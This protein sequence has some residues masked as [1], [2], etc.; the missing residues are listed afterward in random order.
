MRKA[1]LILFI[2]TIFGLGLT[3][4][5]IV[6]VAI[7]AN[8]ANQ[9]YYTLA[10]DATQMVGND[11]WDL[12]FALTG[13]FEFG[14]HVNESASISFVGDVPKT[15]IWKAPTDN[16]EDPIS[17]EEKG[18]SLY[19][20]ESNWGY[21]GALNVSRDTSDWADFG[22]GFYNLT[23][24]V[25]EGNRVYVIQLRD[26]TYR[27]FMIES[28]VN[29]LYTIRYSDLTGDNEMTA[30][31]DKA[32]YEGYHLALFSFLEGKVI[33]GQPTTWDLAFMRYSELDPSNVGVNVEY[34][35][36]GILTAPG[37]LSAQADGVNPE[38]VD[39]EL[40]IDSLSEQ[41]DIIGQDWKFFSFDSG[42]NIIEDRVFF[43]K[44]ADN[45]LWQ[46]YMYDFEGSSTGTY[47]FAKW[48][49]GQIAGVNDPMS[50]LESVTLVP[51]PALSDNEFSVVI[52]S[53]KNKD[54]KIM[55]FDQMGK[56]LYSREAEL[57]N[58]LN[59]FNLS[60]NGL[61]SGNYYVSIKGQGENVVRNLMVK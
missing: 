24:H 27:K 3:A 1:I 28:C 8:Y 57:Q 34:T 18:D 20:D 31:V 15:L 32:D 36:T 42:W 46:L 13:A 43:V 10:D 4:Q 49:L 40:Y 30:T 5:D 16:F 47:T 55:L 54:V 61:A 12:A 14:I 6:Q 41:L 45:N 7:G 29:G 11:D 35:V 51:N 50:E 38:E 25:I 58:G 59:A 21:G 19:N 48:D 52:E 53:G 9:V 17:F 2:G 26:N 44:T 33:D 23:N 22:W 37:V 60:T 39:F 56:L